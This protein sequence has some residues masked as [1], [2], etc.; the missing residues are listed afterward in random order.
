MAEG[1]SELLHI[2][3]EEA[4]EHLTQMNEGLL[5]L[6]ADGGQDTALLRDIFRSAHSLKGAARAVGWAQIESAAHRLEDLFQRAVEDHL[7]I[8]P[9]VAD[10]AYDA[11][12]LIQRAL[13]GLPEDAE[14]TQT[15][16]NMLSTLSAAPQPAAAPA[17]PVQTRVTTPAIQD[18]GSQELLSIF[19]IEAAEHLQMLNEGLLQI[20]TGVMPDSAGLLRE[21]NRSAHSLKG[22]ARAVGFG[23]IETVSH[24]MEEILQSA[25]RGTLALTPEIADSLYDGLDLIQQALDGDETAPDALSTVLEN[26]ERLVASSMAANAAPS[27]PAAETPSASVPVIPAA[28]ARSAPEEATTT[29]TGEM[30]A[31]GLRPLEETIR[32]AVHKL[33]ALMAESSEL[34]VAR[35]QAEARQ[36]RIADLRRSLA[37]WQ[38]EWRSVRAS[39][40]R[41]V[42]R[43]QEQSD[44]IGVEL[45]TLFK[46]LESNQRY[47][48]AMHRDL[49][50]LAQVF[51]QDSMQLAVLA[52]LLQDDVADLRLMPFETIIGGF[53]RMV[54]D[55]ARDIGKQ[56]SLEIQGAHVEIDKAVLDALKDPIMHLLRNAVDHG[57]E[58][59][60]QRITSGKT[61][62][63][64]VRLRVEQRG[65]EI[66]VS[67]E[68]DGRGLDVL[69]I[70]RK[71]IERGLMNEAE[72]QALT[73]DEARLLIFQPGF[74]TSETVTSISGRGLGMDIVRERVE[75]LR[76]R[77]S[78]SSA[79]NQG[80]TV[81]LLVPV[82]LTRIRCILLRVG[83]EDYALPSV[84]VARME[85]LPRDQVFTVEGRE[86]VRVAG[87]SMPLASLGSLLDAGAPNRQGDTLQVV[88]LQAADRSIAFEVD[89][90]YSETE[91]VLKPLGEELANTPY[92]AGAAL[93]GSGDVI[94][95]LDAN[96][97]VRAASGAALP[98]FRNRSSQGRGPR[99]PRRLRVLIVDDSITTRTLEKNILEAVGF[100]VHVAINGEEAWERLSELTPDVIISDVEMPRMDGLELC[101]RVKNNVHTAAIPLVLLTSLAKPEQREAGLKAGADAYLVKSRFDQD[102]LLQ[103]IQAVL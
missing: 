12:D 1:E 57:L 99:Q 16:L 75:N 51:A 13:D 66:G 93:L 41:L 31:L 19:R 81:R 103:T 14:L 76:G 59:P 52:D 48:G 15:V 45:G 77:V 35:M 62:D 47:L 50:Q 101:R 65:S 61:P 18:E 68:D 44:E 40:I 58:T 83:D 42:R 70:R 69:R 7:R 74:S 73:E 55:L 78:V 24:Y 96:D 92:I 82:S 30:P 88:S 46:F 5:R 86:Y 26:L 28:S 87:H 6:E 49:G 54:R 80:T 34:L 2:F 39:Y 29:R 17:K 11:L 43:A 3:R 53:Q 8:T 22:A 91:L 32:V 97:L 25:Q 4:N 95:I 64:V 102:E 98:A 27:M 63:G 37:R 84:M 38:R 79:P 23:L 9:E 21:M 85:T 33:D 90:L 36:R 100:E 10:A 67:V 56:V 72:A 60:E 20:E 94:L 71:A 89:R